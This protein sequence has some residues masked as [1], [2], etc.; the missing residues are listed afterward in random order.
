MAFYTCLLVHPSCLCRRYLQLR[1]CLLGPVVNEKHMHIQVLDSATAGEKASGVGASFWTIAFELSCSWFHH[2]K[3]GSQAQPNPP[4][5]SSLFLCVPSKSVSL[6]PPPAHLP[7]S[8]L[9]TSP[10]PPADEELSGAHLCGLP[11]WRL[12]GQLRDVHSGAWAVGW[13]WW[14]MCGDLQPP[15]FFVFLGRGGASFWGTGCNTVGFRA[16]FGRFRVW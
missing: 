10:P 8:H 7:T 14:G 3:S 15:S 11:E 13:G 4:L 5:N 1:C 2:R 16:T 9:P 6:G 12:R